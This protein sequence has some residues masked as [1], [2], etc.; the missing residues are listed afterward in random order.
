MLTKE[1]FVSIADG[2]GQFAP[3]SIGHFVRSTHP[4]TKGDMHAYKIALGPC[5]RGCTQS[6]RSYRCPVPLPA[7]LIGTLGI[8]F[9]L[10]NRTRRNCCRDHIALVGFAEMADS[11]AAF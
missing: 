3:K 2:D 4:L 1:A 8:A 11:K 5:A 9:F 10:G 7:R 6:C